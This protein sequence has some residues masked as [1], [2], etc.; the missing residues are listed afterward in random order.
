MSG[1]LI[2]SGDGGDGG[3][4]HCAG[5][6]ALAAGP[7]ARCRKPVC[8]DCCVLTTGGAQPWAVCHACNKTGGASLKA[9]WITVL[10]W[11]AK[12]M[13]AV[14]AVYLMLRWLFG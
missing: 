7:C 1:S 6:G 12:P 13:A 8:G 4:V 9:G 14:L 5:C 3:F 2:S 11:I 10:G